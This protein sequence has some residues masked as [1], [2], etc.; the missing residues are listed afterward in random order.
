MGKTQK[1]YFKTIYKFVLAFCVLMT[2]YLGYIDHVMTYYVC[3][4][5]ILAVIGYLL[6]H[7]NTMPL[8]FVFM[9]QDGLE[10]NL[11]RFIFYL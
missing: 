7:Y 6:R 8:I 11:T 10:Q 5:A 3:I 4:S 9:M 2:F 1:L